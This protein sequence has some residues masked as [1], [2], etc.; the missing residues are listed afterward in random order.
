MGGRNSASIA[1]LRRALGGN[2]PPNTITQNAFDHE[3]DH[4]HRLVQL[5]T[6]EPAKPG[7]LWDYTQD[8]RYTEIDRGL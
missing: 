2:S 4:L 1:A 5:E 6:G 8:L 3:A 7:D